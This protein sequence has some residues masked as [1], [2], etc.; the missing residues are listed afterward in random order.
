MGPFLSSL[1]DAPLPDWIS[2][3]GDRPKEISDSDSDLINRSVNF[4]DEIALDLSR[5]LDLFHIRND[6][7]KMFH[8]SINARIIAHSSMSLRAIERPKMEII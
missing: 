7:L 2:S 1:P 5:F 4:I 3:C 8:V 6:A